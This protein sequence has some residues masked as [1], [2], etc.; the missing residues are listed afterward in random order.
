ML[1]FSLTVLMSGCATQSETI[2]TSVLDSTGGMAASGSASADSTDYHISTD[3]T[4][5]NELLYSLPIV[6]SSSSSQKVD[7][8]PVFFDAYALTSKNFMPKTK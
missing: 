7:D 4:E 6:C 5:Y 8:K 2:D 3:Q 1:V